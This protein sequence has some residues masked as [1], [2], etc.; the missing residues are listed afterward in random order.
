MDSESPAVT[1]RVGRYRWVICGLLFAA[2][3]INYVDRQIIGVLKPT[4]QAEYGWSEIDYGDIIFWFQ[5]AYALGYVSFGRVVDRVGARTGYALAVSMWT[6]A[7]MAHAACTSLG[8]FMA[9]RFA[10]GLGEAGNFPSGL[11]AVA[12]WFPKKE[13][14]LAVG[15]FN[16]GANVG[17][18]ITPLIVPVITISLGWRASFLITGLFTVVWLVAWWTMYRRPQAHVRVNAAEL[19]LIQSDPPDPVTPIAWTR[20]LKVRETWAYAAG[21]FLIDPIWWMFLFWL[22]DFFAKRHGLDLKTYG[23]PLVVVYILSDVGSIFGGW[24]SSSLMKR[25]VNLSAARKWAMFVCAVAVLPIMGAMYIDNLWMAVLVVGLA[26]AAHQGFS[27]NLYTLPS[28]LFPRRAVASVVGIGGT[29]GAI[30]GMLMAKY[31]GWVLDALGSY[32][33]IFIVAGTVYLLALLV[34]HLLS[35]N[36]APAKVE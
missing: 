1:M 24:L 21:K 11:K 10:L 12:E 3:A 14:A 18:I 29:A 35:P 26:T 9:A 32:T 8:G 27:C 19:A 4:L 25:G 15:I 30:G 13:R 23:P 2:T 7:H 34:V 5:A 20:L 22:P 28:D 31:A 36:Y 17:A 6:V 33:P 16:A